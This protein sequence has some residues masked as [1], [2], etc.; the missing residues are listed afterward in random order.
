[1]SRTTYPIEATGVSS[2]PASSSPML[3]SSSRPLVLTTISARISSSCSGRDGAGLVGVSGEG[4]VAIL[5]EALLPLVRRDAADEACFLCADPGRACCCSGDVEAG[6][7]KAFVF[8]DVGV[9][10]VPRLRVVDLV[11]KP[12]LLFCPDRVVRGCGPIMMPGSLRNR[13]SELCK[14]GGRKGGVWV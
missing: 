10:A 2:I 14:E 13:Y 7:I 8:E 4:A 1:M 12:L 3:S 6:D 11:P 5:R 9:E